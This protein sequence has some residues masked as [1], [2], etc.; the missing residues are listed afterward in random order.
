MND[1]NSSVAR[2]DESDTRP[3]EFADAPD[4]SGAHDMATP[5]DRD[6]DPGS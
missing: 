5:F 2:Q 1:K 4:V 6:L 3:R